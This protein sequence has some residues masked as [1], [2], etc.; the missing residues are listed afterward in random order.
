M[1]YIWVLPYADMHKMLISP[2]DLLLSYL[3]PHFK[4]TLLCKM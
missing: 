4:Y 1:L 3:K 2:I